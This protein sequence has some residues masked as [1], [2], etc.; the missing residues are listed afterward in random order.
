MITAIPSALHALGPQASISGVGMTGATSAADETKHAA[1]ASFGSQL[2]SA[3]GSLDQSQ[4]AAGTAASG[5]ATGTATDP[6]QAI[7]TVEN[8]S[9]AMDLASSIQS[10]LVTD[11]TTLFSTQM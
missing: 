2:T 5:L 1:G 7:T 3:I 9:L 11:A 10:K 4:N 6:T 8:A